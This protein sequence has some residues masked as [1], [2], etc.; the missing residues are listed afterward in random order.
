MKQNIHINHKPNENLIINKNKK[1]LIP[2]VN[3]IMLKILSN[4]KFEP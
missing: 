4:V 3:G 2:I 1:I